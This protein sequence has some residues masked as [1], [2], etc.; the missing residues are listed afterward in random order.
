M[1][2]FKLLTSNL[3]PSLKIADKHF[4]LPGEKLTNLRELDSSALLEHVE[5]QIQLREAALEKK[6]L[7]NR[8][9]F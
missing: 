4:E 5:A 3:R 2:K 6:M 8:K 1:N 7:L 9:S